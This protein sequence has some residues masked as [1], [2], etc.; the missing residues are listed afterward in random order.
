MIKVTER[1]VQAQY[2]VITM[3]I[4]RI[5]K[6][7]IIKINKPISLWRGKEQYLT[8][9]TG[10]LHSPSSLR[11]FLQNTDCFQTKPLSKPATTA[12]LRALKN[13]CV[14]PSLLMHFGGNPILLIIQTELETKQVFK[15]CFEILHTI[16]G[17]QATAP[18]DVRLF[19][20]LYISPF[21]VETTSSD[22]KIGKQ[23]WQWK[24]EMPSESSIQFFICHYVIKSQ[25]GVQEMGWG[26]TLIPVLM[27]LLW[28][29]FR[30]H[31]RSCN[32]DDL[33]PRMPSLCLAFYVTWGIC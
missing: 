14:S 8:K 11:L 2:W 9:E 15:L 20:T 17:F 28:T 13:S 6:V 3:Y 31:L 32:F 23:S 18:P 29:E 27:F 1:S 22:L 5:P 12:L 25:L 10:V 21:T 24:P 33:H 30:L 19:I 16:R 7:L 26:P 4:F